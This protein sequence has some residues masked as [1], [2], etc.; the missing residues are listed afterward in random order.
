MLRVPTF[1][2]CETLPVG[3]AYCV[4]EPLAYKWKAQPQHKPLLI[5]GVSFAGGQPK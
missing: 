3:I 4:R 1:R 2:S 5:W